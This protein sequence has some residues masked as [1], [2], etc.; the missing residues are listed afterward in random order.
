[1]SRKAPAGF[2]SSLQY[3]W[4]NPQPCRPEDHRLQGLGR[5]V[6]L[7]LHPHPA[8][9][10][11]HRCRRPHRSRGQEREGADPRHPSGPSGGASSA[12]CSRTASGRSRP[13]TTEGLPDDQA[14]DNYPNGARTTIG[15]RHRRDARVGAGGRRGQELSS[16][17]ATG[18]RAR[19]SRSRPSR[20]SRLTSTTTPSHTGPSSSVDYE[21]IDSSRSSGRSRASEDPLRRDSIMSERGR[22]SRWTHFS[23]A[24]TAT[25]AVSPRSSPGNRRQA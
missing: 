4:S 15:R 21:D 19:T 17:S 11:P 2:G 12:R 8:A 22:H 23:I 1:M 7:H 3:D 9:E 16:A 10:R 24:A 18:W 25:A 5:R 14:S 6:G 20:T 13:A